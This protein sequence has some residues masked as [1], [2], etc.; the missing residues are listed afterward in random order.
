[1]NASVGPSDDEVEQ[2]LR[3]RDLVVVAK[4]SRNFRMT[5]VQVV[6]CLVL[7]GLGLLP[8]V[9]EALDVSGPDLL[10]YFL[11][12]AVSMSI[13]SRV[14]VTRGGGSRW[15]DLAAT[16]DTVVI[17][18]GSLWLVYRSGAA[19]SGLWVIHAVYLAINI[20]LGWG[21]LFGGWSFAGPLALSAAFWANGQP[22]EAGVALLVGTPLAFGYLVPHGAVRSAIRERIRGDYLRNRLAEREAELERTRIARDLH[23]GLGAELAALLWRARELSTEP[24]GRARA[25]ELVHAAEASLDELRT[26]V[27]GLRSDGTQLGTFGLHLEGRLSRLAPAGVDVKVLI[28]GKVE[29]TLEVDQRAHLERA[30][31]EAA[32]N[33]FTHASPRAVTV[34]LAEHDGVVNVTIEDD[35]CGFVESA[36]RRSGL[37]HLEERAA[38]LGGQCTV[39]SSPAGTR[40]A[41]EIARNRPQLP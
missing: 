30:V 4:S 24:E 7:A 13:T 17:A 6:V 14:F 40:V 41:I 16:L 20:P 36:D 9:H 34:T 27:A 39:S 19:L 15:F 29:A 28:R 33:A 38:A 1:M 21:W 18:G 32:R 3:E 35:G 31:L 5:A 2:A 23:D 26:I 10:S 8:A 12:V 11:A 37:Q 22:G 25:E